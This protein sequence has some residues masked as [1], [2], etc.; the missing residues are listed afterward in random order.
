MEHIEAFLISLIAGLFSLILAAIVAIE[1]AARGVLAGV[2]ITGSVQTA[3]L[4]LLLLGLIIVALRLF[5]RLFG[6][7]I[8]IVLLI[9]LAHAVVTPHRAD[10]SASQS[11]TM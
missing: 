7:L 6:A 4:A 10:V 1:H 11:V 5:G 3:L 9:V 2:G 8:A